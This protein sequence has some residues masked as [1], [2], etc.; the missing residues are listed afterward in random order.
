MAKFRMIPVSQ[1]VSQLQF[2]CPGCKELHALDTT[3]Q[4]NG[5]LDK[6]TVSPS[7]LVRGWLNEKFPNGVC[8]SFIKDGMIQFLGDCSHELKNQTV[9]LLEIK[10][11]SNGK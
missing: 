9:E 5:N 11:T 1:T 7:V 3:W 6:P 2:M 10:D 4:F 8:H